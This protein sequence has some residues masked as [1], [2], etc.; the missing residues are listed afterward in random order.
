MTPPLAV[1]IDQIEQVNG[2]S[3]GPI[4]LQGVQGPPGPRGPA[5]VPGGGSLVFTQL[6]PSNVW[7]I[8]H[9]FGAYPYVYT[10]DSAQTPMIGDLSYPDNNTAVVTFDTPEAGQAYLTI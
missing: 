8:P 5:G 9:N 2:V 1:T 10:I 4:G 6:T 7:T 3:V